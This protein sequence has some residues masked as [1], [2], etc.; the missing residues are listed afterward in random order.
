MN[1][2]I[3]AFQQAFGNLTDITVVLFVEDSFGKRG[4]TRV[5]KCEE[6]AA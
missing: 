4:G 2:G 6:R 3:D 5:G 1:D